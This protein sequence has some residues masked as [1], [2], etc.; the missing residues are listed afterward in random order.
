MESEVAQLPDFH[1]NPQNKYNITK[2]ILRLSF[3][4][5]SDLVAYSCFSVPD[6]YKKQKLCPLSSVLWFQGH[7]WSLSKAPEKFSHTKL[8]LLQQHKFLTVYYSLIFNIYLITIHGALVSVTH[9]RGTRN[10]WL[11]LTSPATLMD[12]VWPDSMS[13]PSGSL[14]P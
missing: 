1:G 12:A 14:H 4:S 13:L 2:I 9:G 7:S 5:C 3:F 11:M 6:L 10:G 8:P